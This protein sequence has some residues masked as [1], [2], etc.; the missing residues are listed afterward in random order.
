MIR[1]IVF[2]KFKPNV[3]DEQIAELAKG[4]GALPNRIPEIREYSLGRDIMRSERSF[5]FVLVSS[6]ADLDA[7]R[8]YNDH[9]DHQ[10]VLAIARN[11]VEKSVTVDYVV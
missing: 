7:L 10:S 8:R 4:L 11:I 5:D 6:F 2:S 3:A 9:P 1:H